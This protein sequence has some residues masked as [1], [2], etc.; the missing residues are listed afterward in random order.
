[1]EPQLEEK[2]NTNKRSEVEHEDQ[3]EPKKL[4]EDTLLQCP[5]SPI[6]CEHEEEEEEKEEE[7]DDKRIKLSSE[8]LIGAVNTNVHVKGKKYHVVL[9]SDNCLETC[10]SF[11]NEG[12]IAHI[13][14]TD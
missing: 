5:T 7:A 10:Y 8:E 6:Q 1:M 14:L 2:D 11:V 12:D 9:I 13:S 4:K 3:S